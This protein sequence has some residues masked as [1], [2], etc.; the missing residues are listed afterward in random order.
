MR[1]V[2]QTLTLLACLAISAWAQSYQDADRLFTNGED[3]SKDLQALGIATRAVQSSPNDYQWLWRAARGHYF[4]G[5]ASK[6]AER[7]R[8]YQAGVSYGQRATAAQPNAVEGHFWLG[9]NHGGVGEEKGGIRA[10]SIIKKV[11]A[12]MESVLRLNANYA[13][14][15]A[16]LALGELDRQVPGLLGGD[17]KRAINRL[18]TGVRVA[19]QNLEMKY[20][21][22]QAY[23]EAKRIEDARRLLNEVINGSARKRAERNVQIK[24]RALLAK[25]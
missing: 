7:L 14:G 11:R 8:N 21:L 23:Q 19:P 18:E 2:I 6:G 1:Y 9:A 4:V 13:E 25:L 24:A 22:A 17:L 10:L 12:E 16:Y 3:A 5:D 15:S 20:V